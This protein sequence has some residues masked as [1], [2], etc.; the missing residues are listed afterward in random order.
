MGKYEIR[1]MK[2]ETEKETRSIQNS[3]SDQVFLSY[4]IFPISYF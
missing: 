2:S 3:C 1:N 4:F